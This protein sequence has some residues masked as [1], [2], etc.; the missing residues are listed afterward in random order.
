MTTTV[1]DYDEDAQ[2]ADILV[3]DGN[4]SVLCYAHPFVTGDAKFELI[5][6]M[7]E[8]IMRA[9]DNTCYVEKSEDGYYAYKM[10]GRIIDLS[11]GLV[12]V[13]DIVL[14]IAD[15]IP[16]DIEEGEYIEFTVVRIDY[17]QE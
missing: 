2:E 5:C 15:Y 14:E 17:I 9:P 6:F 4:F 11:K 8:D 16:K 3:S 12:A 10:C 1:C 13:G 7:A